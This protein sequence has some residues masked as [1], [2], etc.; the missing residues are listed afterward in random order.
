MSQNLKKLSLFFFVLYFYLG[1]LH[2]HNRLSDIGVDGYPNSWWMTVPID[3]IKSWE[4]P[5]HAADRSKEEVILSKRTELGIFS[6]LSESQFVLDGQ[7]YASIEGLWQG[8]KY[9]EDSNDERL[10]DVTVTWPYTREQVYKMSGFEAK[11]AGDAA[12]ENMKKMGIKWIT[13]QGEK[14]EYNSDKGQDKHYNIIYRASFEKVRQNP[15]IQSL[16]LKT[17]NLI[18]K[19]DHIQQPNPKPAYLYFDIY[20]KIRNELKSKPN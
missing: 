4:I 15:N 3:Q 10:K 8:M 18:L 7:S 5:P 2:A 17:N 19:S 12:N 6:N 16:L 20:M 11:K 13:Y 9:P 14:I 1:C